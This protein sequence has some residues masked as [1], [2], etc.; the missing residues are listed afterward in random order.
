MNMTAKTLTL[1]LAASLSAM[2]VG[3]QDAV[4]AAA[5]A[6]EAAPEAVAEEV[7]EGQNEVVDLPVDGED[8]PAEGEDAMKGVVVTPT[9]NSGKITVSLDAVELEDVVRLFTRLSGA[10]I[11][12]NTTN[13][14][15]TV[16]ANLS[17]IDWEPAFRTI[18]RLQGLDLLE[19]PMTPGVYK[20]DSL[21]PKGQEP[22]VSR[23]FKLNYLKAT[24]A[25][26]ILREFLGLNAPGGQASRKTKDKNG[27]IIEE[28][29][30]VANEQKGYVVAHPSANTV[31]VSCRGNE[32]MQEVEKV[33]KELDIARQQVCIEA[34]IVQVSGEAS[35]RIGID[36][37]FLNGY[38]LTAGPFARNYTKTK[39]RDKTDSSYHVNNDA[40]YNRY[41]AGDAEISLPNAAVGGA[42]ANPLSYIYRDQTAANEMAIDREKTAAWSANS[43]SKAALGDSLVNDVSTAIFDASAMS[44]ML[45]A[46]QTADDVAQ[47]SNP[48]L[49]VANEER[50]VIDMTQKIPYVT[51]D[52]KQDGTGTEATYTYTTEMKE[53]PTKVGK[54]K[55]G[56]ELPTPSYIDGAFFSSGI[57]VDVVPRINNPSNITV[58][59]EPLLSEVASYYTP[60]GENGTRYPILDVR[61]VNTTFSMADGQTAVIGGL[62]QTSDKEVTKKIP[63]LGSIPLLGKYLFSWSSKQK[64]QTETIIFVTVKIVD[65][66][67]KATA[68]SLPEGARLTQKRIDKSGK[69]IDK[70]FDDLKVGESFGDGPYEPYDFD[71]EELTVPAAE[72]TDEAAAAPVVRK[73]QED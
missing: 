61:T 15:G 67:D 11:I 5:A 53:I 16:T 37:S 60:A 27:N 31:I 29:E 36:W 1:S 46:L 58:V 52:M 59:I 48:K 49:I 44:V 55:F 14:T 30:A 33:I 54:D 57:R 45:S 42:V 71:N 72:A 41:Y 13:L 8:A 17:N 26:K 40:T 21:P 69:I 35:K 24:D 9:D 12:C 73:V 32:K 38:T 63:L 66:D 56:N 50:A 64:V 10:N 34:K 43:R 22:P 47:I 20:V 18:L 51:V 7:A 4:D 68:L 19:D 39:T 70:E 2:L 23:S 62:T 25:A 65:P 3:A 6:P 28:V